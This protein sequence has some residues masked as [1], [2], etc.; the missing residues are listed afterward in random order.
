MIDD[1]GMPQHIRNHSYKVRDV[2]VFMTKELNKKGNSLDTKLIESCA[3]IH[4]IVKIQCVR[5]E[6]PDFDNNHAKVGADILRKMGCGRM[7]DIIAQHVILWKDYNGIVEDEIINYSDK[8]VRHDQLVSLTER[9]DDIKVRY[10]SKDKKVLR[11]IE[12]NENGSLILE[13]KIFKSLD[14]S[15]DDLIDLI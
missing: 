5:K 4:D 15:P 14:F 6:Y 1:Y 12:N 10:A 3:L 11:G 2:A 13:T 8:R 7:A 9:F